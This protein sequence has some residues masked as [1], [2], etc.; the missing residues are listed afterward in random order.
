MTFGVIGL[1]A[2]SDAFNRRTDKGGAPA[3]RRWRP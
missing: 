2:T 3:A 1:L